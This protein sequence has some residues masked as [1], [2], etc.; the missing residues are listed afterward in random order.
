M[1][2]PVIE[3]ARRLRL[4]VSMAVACCIRSWSWC[5][6][7]IAAI[8]LAAKGFDWWMGLLLGVFGPLG[9]VVAGDREVEPATRS[10][11]PPPTGR[12]VGRPTRHAGTSC[13]CGTVGSGRRTS[14]IAASRGCGP[15]AV[16]AD[17]RRAFRASARDAGATFRAIDVVITVK[18]VRVIAVLAEYDGFFSRTG[19]GQ[20][21]FRWL[22]ILVGITWIGLLYYFNF[23]QVPAFAQ[24]ENE[25]HKEIGGKA[26]NIALDKVARRALWWFRWS[27]LFTFA[28]RD[29]DH[30]RSPR[31]TSRTS[32]ASAPAAWRSSTGML[33]GIIMLL[34]VW[35]VIWREPEDRARQRGQRARRRRSPTRTPRPPAA[36]RCMAS[37]QNTI[38][39]ISM[40]YFMVFKPATAP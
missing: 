40:L 26:R 20:F 17:R 38:F 2:L 36:R 27:A 22:H 5:A 30:R 31:T 37:R 8:I 13:G 35:G 1:S 7:A 14:A 3:S 24:F 19:L 11:P 39:S 33:L 23:V 4:L 9:I 25:P 6:A 12:A 34:N 18:E 21:G 29:P 10:L 28:H 32:S 15:A 16:S